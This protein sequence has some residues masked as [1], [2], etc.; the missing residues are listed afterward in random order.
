MSTGPGAEAVDALRDAV[1]GL[2][3][4]LVVPP[5]DS[6]FDLV[7]V[8]PAGDRIP[9]EV[10][11]SVLVSAD[12]LAQRLKR[13]TGQH[14]G[15]AAAGVLVADRVT[16]D[17]RDVLR[18]AG[19]GW[20]DLRGHLHLV[21]P[22]LFID[23]SV[24]A[25]THRPR[26][27]EPLTGTVGLEVATSLLL[28]PRRPVVVR[29]LARELGRSASSVS[30]VLTSMRE[31]GLI[32]GQRGPMLPELFWETAANWRPVQS[33]IASLPEPGTDTVSQ[34]LRLGLDSGS[35]TVG[36]ALT[37]TVAAAVYGA[38]VGARSD[39]PPDFYVP[40]RS[41]LRRALH[42]LGQPR[43]RGNRAGTVR[44]APV[45][46]ICADRVDGASSEWPLAQPLFVA[47]DLAQDPDRGRQI[48]ASWTPPNKEHRVW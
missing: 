11:R 2:G 35:E 34:A 36:W 28:A 4:D 27:S 14:S 25:T 38:P 43:D 8:T 9:I 47:L 21:G 22:G 48:L 26:R 12:G 3:L 1:A 20:L 33:D 41:T 30:E 44:V 18:G 31:A 13:W 29:A 19:W 24:P 16:A 7:L 45:S 5:A 40:D 32:N 10:K 17:A 23:T 42:L 39:H 6:G 46:R 15:P 37:D